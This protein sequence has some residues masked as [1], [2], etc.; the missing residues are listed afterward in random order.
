MNPV[1]RAVFDC[2]IYFQALISRSGP[3]GQC[4]SAAQHGK[5]LL[6]TSAIVI[7]EFRDVCLRPRIASRFRLSEESVNA[8]VAEIEHTAMIVSEV[9]KIFE[10]DRDPDDA[11]YVDLAVAASA[12]LIVSRDQDL[13]ALSDPQNPEAIFFKS[14][15]P[16]ISI[17]TPTELLALLV[18]LSNDD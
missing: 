4:F 12:H 17:L 2:N 15:F 1:E 5:L 16:E 18:E 6:F 3:A 9:P 11:H 10:Y 8:F 7:N 13:L 14:R